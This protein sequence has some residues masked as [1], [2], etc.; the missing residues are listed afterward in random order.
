MRTLR[1]AT[2]IARA[3]SASMTAG[4]VTRATH[5]PPFV[6]GGRPGRGEAGGWGGFVVWRIITPDGPD[7][8]ARND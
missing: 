4:S 2:A 6:S 1:A 3:S 7:G 5:G 8:L